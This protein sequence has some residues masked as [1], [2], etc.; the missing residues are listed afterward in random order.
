[1]PPFKGIQVERGTCQYLNIEINK[2]KIHIALIVYSI[3]Y[4]IFKN[5]DKYK[6]LNNCHVIFF[7]FKNVY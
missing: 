4:K 7:D 6:Y 2:F 3:C 5:C 1:M